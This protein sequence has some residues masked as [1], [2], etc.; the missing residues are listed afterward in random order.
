MSQRSMFSLLLLS[1]LLMGQ[2]AVQAQDAE[3]KAAGD[4]KRM[5]GT[6]KTTKVTVAGKP[7]QQDY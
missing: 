3:A 4:L 7:G 6:W 1:T 5:V 2:A